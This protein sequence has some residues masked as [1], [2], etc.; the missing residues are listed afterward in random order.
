M[1]T[2]IKKHSTTLNNVVDTVVASF[3]LAIMLL[4]ATIFLP[5]FLIYYSITIGVEYVKDKGFY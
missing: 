1:R 4:G 5:F 2:D 3:L